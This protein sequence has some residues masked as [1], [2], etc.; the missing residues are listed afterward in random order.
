MIQRYGL[1][2]YH[3]EDGRAWGD[4]VTS[5]TGEYITFKDYEAEKS[6]MSSNAVLVAVR[7]WIYDNTFKYGGPF[8]MTAVNVD[9]L[10][11]FLNNLNEYGD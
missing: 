5:D 8:G 3:T 6:A 11:E 1:V 10:M 2:Q 7:A 4:L 9:D